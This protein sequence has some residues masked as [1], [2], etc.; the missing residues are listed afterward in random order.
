M[1]AKQAMATT[2]HSPLTIVH[3][4]TRNRHNAELKMRKTFLLVLLL[5]GALKHGAANDAAVQARNDAADKPNVIYIMA[6]ALGYGDLGCYAQKLIQPPNLDRMAREGMRFT[7][8][9]AAIILRLSSGFRSMKA[10]G[11]T[12]P[13][14]F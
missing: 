10:G 6:D 1:A 7:Q 11:S 12:T 8:M 3:R 2:N 14:T 9:Y 5:V 4:K 13:T